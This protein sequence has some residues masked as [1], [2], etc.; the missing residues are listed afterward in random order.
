MTAPVRSP[1]VSS[2]PKLGLVPGFDGFRGTGML[3]VMLV[4]ATGPLLESWATMVDSFFVLSGFL[5]TTLLLQESRTTGGI[6]MRK[7]YARRATRLF[8]SLWL[9]VGVWLVISTIATVAGLDVLSLRD[10]GADALAVVGYVYH[11]FFPVGLAT[12]AP[13]VQEVRTMWHLW[14]LSVEEWFYL[15]IPVTVLFCIR[16]GWIRQLGIM[17]VAGAAA[18]GV[19][20]FFA[21]TGFFQDSEGM[22][23]GIRLAFLQRPDGL[24][25]GVAL[26]VVNAYMTTAFI[27]RHRR[28]VLALA[29]VAAAVW[30]VT[31]NAGSE[32][33]GRL[34]LPHLPYLPSTPEGFN[35]QDMMETL[36]W[37]RFGHTVCIFSFAV[38]TFA[39][40]HY[41]DWWLSRFWS[42]GAFQYVGRLSYTLYIWHGLPF[43]I[44]LG[45]TGGEEA[46]TAVTLL[47]IPVMFALTFLVAI[48]VYRYV[49]MPALRLKLRFS[50]ESEVLDR[51]TG[52]LVRSG[53][54][55]AT[56]GEEAAPATS[57]GGDE[58]VRTR[59]DAPG[60]PGASSS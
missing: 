17:M 48:P 15:V 49:E 20:R 10:V 45:L 14:T 18:I 33:I 60:G 59:D 1:F 57:P 4:H 3:L 6:S 12:I 28:R 22:L 7:F 39:L 31:L 11:L 23:P 58:V 30:A 51:R 19:A 52:Q 36:Y 34:G 54:V 44:V 32:A 27:E 8:P 13:D 37:F 21:I 40:V 5:I 38:M 56:A 29:T 43:L 25:I 24:M 26:A 2:A 42:A 9:F 55:A 41:W 50:S 16:R 35:R 47:R 46:S 53:G